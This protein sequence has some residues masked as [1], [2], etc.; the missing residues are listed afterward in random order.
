MGAI[1]VLVRRVAAVRPFLRLLIALI[2]TI[3][4]LN[5]GTLRIHTGRQPAEPLHRTARSKGRVNRLERNSLR[6]KLAHNLIKV[7]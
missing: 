3:I 1:V 5:G 6:P 2:P 4:V 7:I